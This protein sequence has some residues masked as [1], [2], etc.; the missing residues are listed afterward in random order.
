VEEERNLNELDDRAGELAKPVGGEA[1]QKPALGLAVDGS[2][3]RRCLS[4]FILMN[5]LVVAKLAVDLE[6]FRDEV[7]EHGGVA[8]AVGFGDLGAKFALTAFEAAVFE[9]MERAFDLFGERVV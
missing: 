5:P 8:A 4:G 6:L 3:P 7:V 9:V 1:E 2:T